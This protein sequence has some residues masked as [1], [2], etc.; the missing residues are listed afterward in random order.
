MT[1]APRVFTG[2]TPAVACDAGGRIVAVGADA[3]DFPGA[4]RVNLRGRAL[5]G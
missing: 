3:L 5:P 1:P 2:C 4:A